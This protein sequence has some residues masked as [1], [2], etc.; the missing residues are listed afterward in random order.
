MCYNCISIRKLA[1]STALLAQLAHA[2]GI[3]IAQPGTLQ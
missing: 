3:D 2:T 1:E